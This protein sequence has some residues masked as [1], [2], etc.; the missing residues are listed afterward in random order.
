MAT[1]T[2]N[3]CHL[4]RAETGMDDDEL[5]S[6]ASRC[7]GPDN[8]VLL[9]LDAPLGW[10][11]TMGMVLMQHQ[12]GQGIGRDANDLY[13][14]RTDQF[15]KEE[16][17]LQSLDVGADR[18]A[19]TA[20]SALQLLETLRRRCGRPIPLAVDRNFT[21]MAAIEV[22]PAATLKGYNLQFRK[23]KKPEETTTR[24]FI[25]NGLI[26]EGMVIP[27]DVRQTLLTS[28]DALDAAVCVLAGKDFLND[29]AR[30]PEEPSEREAATKEG[31]IWV[32]KR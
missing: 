5:V 12:A 6:V 31:W 20:H 24:H 25:M 30:P 17:G 15:I 4:E 22:Y 19:R 10:P 29:K 26:K 1:H 8:R 18:I 21:G 3:A 23:Y 2:G 27:E 14:R 16:Y 11:S 9:A 13:R 28:S 32:R 7:L